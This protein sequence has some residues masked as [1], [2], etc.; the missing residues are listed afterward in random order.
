MA[1]S[2]PNGYKS[3][4]STN[5]QPVGTPWFL[6]NDIYT[7][8]TEVIS[9]GRDGDVFQCN[10]TGLT[11]TTANVAVRAGAR[12]IT[13][14]E[15]TALTTVRVTWS[16]TPELPVSYRV[17]Y[18]LAGGTG[19][20]GT[21]TVAAD[22]TSTE[23]TGL[24]N[25]ET[26]IISVEVV[27]SLPDVIPAVAEE[28]ITLAPDTPERVVVT[29]ESASVRVSWDAVEDADRY[30]VTFSQ[31]RGYYQQGLCNPTN[32]HTAT[33]TVSAPSTTVSIA[34]GGDVGSTV[35]DML[36]AYTTY[37][38]TVNAV[39]DVRGTSRP[40]ETR[41]VLT[42][43][44]SAGEAPGDV[45]AEAE[46]PTEIS[47]QWSG[48]SNCRLVNGPI[49][50][51]RVQFTAN[52]RAETVDQVLGDGEDWMSGGRVTLTGLTS[53]T[54]YSISVAAVNENGDVGLYS[55]PL[56]VLTLQAIVGLAETSYTIGE[57]DEVVEVCINAVGTTSSCPSTESFHVTLST[58]DQTAESP[59]DYVAVDQVLTFAA[60][61]SQRCVNVSLAN[62][63]VSEPEETF[64]LS[65]TRSTRS[66]ISITSATG[67][68]VITDD[69]E[70]PAEVSFLPVN[71]TGVRISW[72][73]SVHLPTSIHYT[74]SS[75]PMASSLAN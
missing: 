26:Y 72:S 45:R 21:K 47:V 63:L 51:Y 67:V 37:E 46:S 64:S 18:L 42:P 23:I 40:R 19:G 3:D 12:P 16:P 14:L 59:A 27:S 52:G 57:S 29:A 11:S 53:L 73:G 70:R 15:Q 55:D 68:V 71:A 62:D 69:D 54:N 35:T 38:V 74:V 60:C 4:I 34:V 31:V 25:R 61:E 39:S 8:R 48:L 10:A 7:A 41:R 17:H 30:T 2:G 56:T 24:T 28:I 49:T 75:P 65:L 44:T 58:S 1:V 33:L 43:Q 20:N 66:H 5:I 36:R 50:Q 22:T 6:S 9:S 32:S 13:S